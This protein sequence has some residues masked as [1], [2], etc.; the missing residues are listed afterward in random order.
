M[1]SLVLASLTGGHREVSGGADIVFET[2]RQRRGADCREPRVADKVS[3]ETEVIYE[4]TNR[5]AGNHGNSI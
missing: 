2:E 5:K 3:G 4:Y 1:N